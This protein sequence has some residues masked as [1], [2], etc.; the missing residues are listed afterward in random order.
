[1]VSLTT[2]RLI[3]R[4]WSP[5]DLAARYSLLSDPEVLRYVVADGSPTLEACRRDLDWHIEQQTKSP[6]SSYALV[7][8]LREPERVIGGSSLAITSHQHHE[9]ELAYAL[10][11]EEWGQGYILEATRALLAFGFMTL[12]L[13]RVFATCDPDN[14]ASVR[15]LQKLGMRQEGQLRENTWTRGTWR[16]SLLYALLRQEFVLTPPQAQS[17]GDRGDPP[18]TSSLSG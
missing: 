10:R 6:R 13:H 18:S 16:D 9:A 2:S 14:R 11:S 3:L 15:V 7:V 1:M 12:D 4:E 5:D 17:E 8:C